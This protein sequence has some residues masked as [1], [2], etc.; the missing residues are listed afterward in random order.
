MTPIRVFHVRP[1]CRSRL[2]LRVEIF[3]TTTEFRQAIR[4]EDRA[5][6]RQPI[7]IRG[8]VGAC[9]GVTERHQGRIADLFAIV[10][11]PRRH[12]TMSTITHEAFHAT[13][14]WAARQQIPAIPTAGGPS[15]LHTAG[16]AVS[17]E[18]RCAIIHDTIC[19][20]IV[21]NLNR[22]KLLPK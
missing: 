10:R 12:L 1:D 4:A 3:R 6:G 19:R 11:L 9:T 15:N 20:K 14:R 7:R 16:R 2:R 17:V 13:L 18:E 21:W 22:F 8:L 5:F